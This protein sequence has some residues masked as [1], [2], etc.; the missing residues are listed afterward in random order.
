MTTS[1][2]PRRSYSVVVDDDVCDGC[3]VCI[4]FCKPNV[5][6]ISRELSQ[7]GFFPA[8]VQQEEDCNNC[9]LCELGCPQ[10]AISVEEKGR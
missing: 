1:A 5:F 4:F 3:G 10:L 7:R 8:A 9:R 2:K 6:A